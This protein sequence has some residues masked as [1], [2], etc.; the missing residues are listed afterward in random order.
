[1]SQ[2]SLRNYE[3]V[4]DD[5]GLAHRLMSVVQPPS[6]ALD[7]MSALR[8]VYTCPPQH[9]KGTAAGLNHQIH[10]QLLQAFASRNVRLSSS[11]LIYLLDGHSREV[12]LGKIRSP[13]AVTLGLF[14]LPP[15]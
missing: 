4:Q 8:L 11:T 5:V 12:V 9:C 1:M 10:S 14:M 3:L 2:L 7:Q 15:L 13:D 6:V